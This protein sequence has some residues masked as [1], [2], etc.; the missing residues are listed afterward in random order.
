MRYRWKLLLLLL[1]ISV[2]PILLMR[3]FGVIAV[4]QLG[5]ELVFRIQQDRLRQTLDRLQLLVDSYAE[6]LAAGSRQVEIA[7]RHQAQAVEHALANRQPG[8]PAAVYSSNDFRDPRRRPQDTAP[9]SRHLRPGGD[10][11]VSFSSQVF[12]WAPIV[13]ARQIEGDLARLASITPVYQAL[14]RQLGGLALWQGTCLQSG[15]QGIFPG[16]AGGTLPS[17]PRLQDWYREGLMHDMHWSDPISDPLTGQSVLAAVAQVRDEAGSVVGATQLVVPVARL[18]DRSLLAARVPPATCILVCHPRPHPETGATAARILAEECPPEN[19]AADGEESQW[20]TSEDPAAL[21]AVLLDLHAGSGGSRRMPFRGHD[22]HWV[23]GPA[24]SGVFLVV[25]TPQ[26]Q[27]MAPANEA[28]AYVDGLI[29]RLLRFTSYGVLVILG[30]ILMLALAFARTVTRPLQALVT[31]AQRLAG[32]D[33]DARVSIASRDEFG[34]MGRVFN[35][36]GPRLKENLLMRQALDVAREVQQNLM[37]HQVPPLAG[38][39]IAGRVIYCD[40]TGGD[41]YDFLAGHADR[42]GHLGIIVADAS[43]HGISAALLMASARAFLRQR[44]AMPGTL[45]EMVADVN[46]RLAEDVGETGRFVSLLLFDADPNARMLHWVRAGHPPGLIYDPALDTLFSLEGKGPALGVVE[47]AL[48]E[49]SMHPFCPDQVLLVA[50]DGVWEARGKGGEMFGKPSLQQIL[51]ERCTCGASEILDAVFEGLRHF[52]E[53]APLEDD[54]TL[55]V[56]KALKPSKLL[57]SA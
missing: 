25:I 41:F 54:A 23:Y 22:S 17:D 50:T 35:Q 38:L 48:F 53:D 10:L 21:Q 27:I 32:G 19:A 15:I 5:E 56:I 49:E 57:E 47:G 12:S 6:V 18:I 52:R 26:S 7:L 45:A 29:A 1:A 55:V 51:R 33:F 11:R 14:A 46:C 30:V 9:S 42:A 2:I 8:R 28:R 40:Q 37:P 3:L 39:D 13:P 31:G 24:N 4:R 16:H 20:L 34:D 36:V 43:D 44:F